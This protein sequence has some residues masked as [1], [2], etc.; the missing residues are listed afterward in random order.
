MDFWEARFGGNAAPAAI[1]GTQSSINPLV[2]FL[3]KFVENSQFFIFR[4]SNSRTL[5]YSKMSKKTL[6]KP[7]V[8]SE[9]CLFSK[10]INSNGEDLR[11]LLNGLK[12][13]IVK[14]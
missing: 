5:P 4:K 3:P 13:R 2:N 11:L 10:Q 6:L 9:T 1:F 8:T 14:K 12:S 7:I